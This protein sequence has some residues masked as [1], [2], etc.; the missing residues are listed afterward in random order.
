MAEDI[1]KKQK[2]VVA[3]IVHLGEKMVLPTGMTYTSAIDLLQRRMKYEEEDTRMTAIFETFPWD[4][5]AALKRALDK[6]YGWAIAE[7]TP[8]MFGDQPP[9]LIEIAIDAKGGKI[10]VPWG[11]FSLPGI[12][13]WLETGYGRNQFSLSGIFKRKHEAEVNA[14]FQRVREELK[15]KSL[16]RGKAFR[17]RWLDDDGDLKNIPDVNFIETDDIDEGMLIFSSHVNAAVRTNLF[18]PISRVRELSSN[19]IPVK[20]GILL[21]G[22]FGTG[23]SMAAKVA[24]KFAVEAGVT[25]VYV[26]RAKELKYAIEFARKYQDPACVIFC[27]DID[28]ETDGER[29]VEMDD[30]L[31]I[32]DGIDSKTMNLF[33]VLTT[34][35]L[36]GINAAMLR[37]GRLDAVIEVTPPDA[38][39]VERLLRSYGGGSISSKEDLKEV[40]RLLNGRIP[41]VIAEVVKRAKLHEL[42]F[43][44]KGEKV[45]TISEEALIEAA[46]TMNTQLDLLEKKMEKKPPQDSLV[47]ALKGVIKEA[48]KEIEKEEAEY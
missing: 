1:G 4:G 6:H 18:T 13:G 43:T 17:M 20:R 9:Q 19:N 11:R 25:F 16:Y 10:N 8:S 40:S 3:E 5:A 32:I 46:L 39:A 48:S 22:T 24:S 30:L 31:N 27:E 42:S 33:V 12:V 36:D 2:V 15:E 41:A 7:K 44:P 23:K 35:N 28:R 38:E 14:L 37:P 26:Q 29:D 47:S 21:G 45:G 34:N